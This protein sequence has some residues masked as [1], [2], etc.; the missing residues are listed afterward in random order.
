MAVTVRTA[1]T[2]LRT[3]QKAVDRMSKLMSTLSNILEKTS[4]TSGQ[5]TQ[6]LK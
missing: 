2:E 1:N 3:A 5:I 6:N 4:A